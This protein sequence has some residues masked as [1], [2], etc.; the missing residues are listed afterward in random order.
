[1]LCVQKSVTGVTTQIGLSYR[2]VQ[3][4]SQGILGAGQISIVSSGFRRRPRNLFTISRYSVPD[5]AVKQSTSRVC[6]ACTIHLQRAFDWRT[7]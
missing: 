2:V 1:M 7:V 5:L 6:L 3:A 4:E